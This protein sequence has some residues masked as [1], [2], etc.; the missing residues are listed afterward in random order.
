MKIEVK[1]HEI[2]LTGF[3][4]A[5]SDVAALRAALQDPGHCVEFGEV[6][7]VRLN[8]HKPAFASASEMALGIDYLT[9]EFQRKL[10]VEALKRHK[11][12]VTHTAQT[13]KVTPRGLRKMMQ[14]LNISSPHASPL[15][16]A[17]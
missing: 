11:N 17:S 14:R 12:N 2:F 4:N 6:R 3:L 13:L 8:T 9:D 16:E 5:D 7:A 1:N 10:I 15:A